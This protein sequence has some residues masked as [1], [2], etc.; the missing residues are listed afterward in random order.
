MIKRNFDSGRIKRIPVAVHFFILWL[1]LQ[2]CA[3][4]LGFPTYYDPTTYKNLTYL[5]PEVLMLYDSFATDEPDSN[6]LESIRL[7]FDQMIEYEI[8]KGKS[9]R[10]TADQC[11]LIKGMFDRDV[12]DRLESGQPWREAHL[13]NKKENISEAFDLAISTEN[14]KNKNK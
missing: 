2:S 13:N 10:E 14:L 6:G 11:K 3:S 4:F 9:N 1:L 5:K 12:K 8:G 7:K